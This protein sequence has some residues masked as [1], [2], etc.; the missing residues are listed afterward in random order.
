MQASFASNN[1]AAQKTAASC[2]LTCSS[3]LQVGSQA[4]DSNHPSTSDAGS[5]TSATA[6]PTSL[7]PE[8]AVTAVKQRHRAGGAA[9]AAAAT[10]VEQ[11][12]PDPAEAARRVLVE[13]GELALD[14]GA[15]CR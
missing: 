12:L 15:A 4:C 14:A 1:L 6:A 2:G 10:V 7:L 8:L 11:Q 13:L 3:I 9:A 5:G